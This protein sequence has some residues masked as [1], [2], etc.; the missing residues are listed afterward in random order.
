MTTCLWCPARAEVPFTEYPAPLAAGS[1]DLGCSLAAMWGNVSSWST[2]WIVPRTL[3]IGSMYAIYGNIY[4]QY[5]PNVSIYTIHGSYVLWYILW[6]SV[7]WCQIMWYEVI[8]SECNYECYY[9]CFSP[10]ISWPICNPWCWNMNPNICPIN[11]YKWPS[12]VGKYTYYTWSIWVMMS[13]SQ[14]FH[15]VVPVFHRRPALWRCCSVPGKRP[16]TCHCA[17]LKRQT[18]SSIW[19]FPK[20][21]GYP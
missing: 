1:R 9:E 14:N 21:W 8:M 13:D 11:E 5:T 19:G 12:H 7:R 10:W 15:L 17:V 6:L 4:H 18:F 16:G 3:P 20:S 2:W